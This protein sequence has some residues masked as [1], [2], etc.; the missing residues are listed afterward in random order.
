MTDSVLSALAFQELQAWTRL[1]DE[2]QLAADWGL[3]ADCLDDCLTP[4]D[5]QLALA[6][7]WLRS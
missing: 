6:D 4:E 3:S 2:Y 7:Q 5:A 1:A